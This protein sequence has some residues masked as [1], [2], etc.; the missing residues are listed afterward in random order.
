MT[1][2]RVLLLREYSGHCCVWRVGGFWM[3]CGV[4]CVRVVAV[5]AH[6]GHPAWVSMTVLVAG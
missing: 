4:A 5:V 6:V 2:T 3:L 1:M